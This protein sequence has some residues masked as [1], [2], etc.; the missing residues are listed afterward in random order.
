VA[1]VDGNVNALTTEGPLSPQLVMTSGGSPRL[2]MSRRR[3]N[4]RLMGMLTPMARSRLWSTMWH[5]HSACVSTM[6]RRPSQQP[7]GAAVVPV[8]LKKGRHGLRSSSDVTHVVLPDACGDDVSDDLDGETGAGV[9]DMENILGGP[10]HGEDLGCHASPA[11]I[12]VAAAATVSRS[13]MELAAALDSMV[14]LHCA[15]R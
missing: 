5:R 9:V 4:A 14:N 15:Q 10:S 11:V 3:R 13:M 12:D 1:K 7:A 2:Q 8:S 6:V